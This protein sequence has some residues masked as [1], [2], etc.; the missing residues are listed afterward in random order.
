MTT[1]TSTVQLLTA[2]AYRG[3]VMAIH[4]MIFLGTTP[5]GGPLV[6]FV[7]D[8]I[9]ARA[10]VALGGAGC[11]LAAAYGLRPRGPH[12]A[13]APTRDAATSAPPAG[14]LPVRTGR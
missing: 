4:S 3:R 10:G 6:G 1:A 2:P 7:S 8:A 13:L 5:I 12:A 14:E 11:I 9:G